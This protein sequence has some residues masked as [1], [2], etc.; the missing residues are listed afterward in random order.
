MTGRETGRRLRVTIGLACLLENIVLGGEA[1][2]RS[3]KPVP[4][5]VPVVADLDR[6]LAKYVPA[7]MVFDARPLPEKDRNLLRRLVAAAREID[8]AFWRQSY[9]RAVEIRERLRTARDPLSAKVLRLVLINGG[10]F[11]RLDEFRPFYGTEKFP[12]GAG[13]YPENLTKKEF[14]AYLEA[15]PD[16]REALLSNYTVVRRAKKGLVAVPYHVEYARWMKPAARELAAAAT[17]SENASFSRYLRSRARALLND[18][19]F[20]SDCDWIDLKDN[21]YE[22]VL[23]PY[24]VYEDHLMGI[25]ASYEA[26]VAIRD[27]EESAR[28]GTYIAHLQELENN[29]P[30]PDEDR[31]KVAGLSSPMVVVRAIFR[32]GN[33]RVGYQAAAANLPNDPKVHQAK[34]TKK[35]FWKNV[36][37]AR[38]NQVI[39]PISRELVAE[40]QARLVTPQAVFENVLMHELAH[41]LGPRYIRGTEEKVSVN[42]KLGELYSAIEEMKATVAGLVSIEWFF[43]H[44]IMPRSSAEE[45]Y[46]SYLGSIFRAIRFGV[47]E[48]HGRASIV[49]LNFARQ[50]GAIR[51]DGETGRW[52]VNPARMPGSLRALAARLLEIERTGDRAAAEAL[53]ARYGVVPDDLQG[54]LSRLETIPVEIEPS[55]RILW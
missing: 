3:P 52:S 47:S 27:A 17:L 26:S 32:A 33:A 54:D 28:L 7:E 53:F 11:D 9:S 50:E 15:H 55:F 6:R 10:P 44:D 22:L 42:L 45:H 16:Q 2:K 4:D 43:D 41:A 49:E 46:A 37:E 18:D 38:V 25:K 8:E 1:E 20:E 13:F 19:Y 48:A 39:L 23:A 34:G 5:P 31:R 12:P 21:P 36:M 40:S 24:E 35:I 29:L 30:Y 14:E 51:R